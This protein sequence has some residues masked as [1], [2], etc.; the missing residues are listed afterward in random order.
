MAEKVRSTLEQLLSTAQ[1]A[2]P[3]HQMFGPWGD[4]PHPASEPTKHAQWSRA[5]AQGAQ[6]LKPFSPQNPPNRA[7]HFLHPFLG[8]GP[9]D[10]QR[11]PCHPYDAVVPSAH[12]SGKTAHPGHLPAGLPGGC[13]HPAA[14]GSKA[15]HRHI[16]HHVHTLLP[17]ACPQ[18][19]SRS[20][21]RLLGLLISST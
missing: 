13:S 14:A 12:R 17:T 21:S 6:R 9:D 19:T 16:R 10:L 1:R 4:A 3:C 18:L 2:A 15:Q 8:A 7:K 20:G 5:Q 11:S